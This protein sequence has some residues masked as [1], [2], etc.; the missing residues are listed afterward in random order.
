MTEY[1][2]VGKSER[3]TLDQDKLTG[4]SRFTA[5]IHPP[6][7]IYGKISPDRQRAAHENVRANR[8]GGAAPTASAGLSISRRELSLRR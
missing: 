1:S 7:M 5:D 3:R 2:Y 4:K 8:P 6:G